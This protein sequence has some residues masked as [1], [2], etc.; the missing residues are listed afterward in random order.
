MTPKGV[1]PHKL[2]FRWRIAIPPLILLA[3]SVAA[4]LNAFVFLAGRFRPDFGE[5]HGSR[6][7]AEVRWV[8]RRVGRYV[9]GVQLNASPEWSA[10]P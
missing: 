3:L 7:R 6:F 4:L 2:N 8:N 10:R 5:V 9:A 1:S